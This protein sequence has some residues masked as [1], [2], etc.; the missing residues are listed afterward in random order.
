MAKTL[1]KVEK[2]EVVESSKEKEIRELHE[3]HKKLTEFGFNRIG[4]IEARLAELQK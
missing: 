2:L 1:E 4:Q 3:L